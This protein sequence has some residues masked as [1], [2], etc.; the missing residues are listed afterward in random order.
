MSR[1]CGRSRLAILAV[2]IVA[3]ALSACGSASSSSGSPV[4]SATAPASSDFSAGSAP[5]ASSGSAAPDSSS[6]SGDAGQL[7][8]LQQGQ[9][10]PSAPANNCPNAPSLADCFTEAN[11][12]V[13]LQLVLPEV[14][15]FFA[16]TWKDMPMPANVY[17]VPVGV[18]AP[19]GC[20]DGNGNAVVADQNSYEYCADD[21]DVYIGQAEA[22][23]L[24]SQAGDVAPAMGLS[25]EDGHDAQEHAQIPE[26][27]NDAETWVHEEQADCVSGAWA[28]Y[29]ISQGWFEQEDIPSIDRYLNMI[30]S[31]G[32]DPNRTHGD[33][34]ER[35][36]AINQG[37][38]GGIQSCNSFYPNTPL[39][40]SS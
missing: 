8:D 27:T 37:L 39:I 23:S 26:P 24:Y 12:G 13:Y 20:E 21:D 16:A 31:S 38:A 5:A 15:A 10:V 30:A 34:Q 25:H 1:I 7:V 17:L 22:W 2:M 18:T 6:D 9:A 33:L 14:D 19:E 28:R 32:S 4:P 29:A 3:L 36:A 40:T 35:A 11:I